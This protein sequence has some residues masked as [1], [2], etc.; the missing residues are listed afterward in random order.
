M[1]N[2]IRIIKVICLINIICSLPLVIRNRKVLDVDRTNRAVIQQNLEKNRIED[3]KL[4]KKISLDRKF[5]NNVLYIH[6]WYG[7][8]D[9]EVIMD[10]FSTTKEWSSVWKNAYQERER[11]FF[12]GGISLAALVTLRK[13]REKEGE[14]NE[15]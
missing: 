6:Y 4:I 11:G 1:E 8:V 15:R 10:G 3:T 9:S 5:N 2:V 14:S 7:R 13:L 12:V